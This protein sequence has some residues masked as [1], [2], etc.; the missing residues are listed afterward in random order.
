[1]SVG[2]ERCAGGHLGVSFDAGAVR[3]PSS[4]L[5]GGRGTAPLR[6]EHPARGRGHRPRRRRRRRSSQKSA[7]RTGAVLPEEGLT[8]GL[9]RRVTPY[10]QTTLLFT[11]PGRLAAIAER[12]GPL[13]VVASGKAHPRDAAGK[14]LIAGLFRAAG[15][16]GEAVRLVFI[17]NYDLRLAARL[18]AGTDLWLNTPKAPLEASGTSGMKAAVNGVPSLSVLDGW[19]LEGCIEGVTGWAVGDGSPDADDAEELYAKL[20][21]VAAIFFSEAARFDNRPPE[22]HLPQ[23]LVLQ[24]RSNGP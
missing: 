18:C 24:H 23:R 19:W 11:D 10:K 12:H 15:T 3:R 4:G 21:E 16:L 17:E 1:M 13:N 22:R 2:D 5:A 7:R 6:L 8:I 9:A 14:E 20:E